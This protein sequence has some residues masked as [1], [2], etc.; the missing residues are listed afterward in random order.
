MCFRSDWDKPFIFVSVNLL[1]RTASQFC[2]RKLNCFQVNISDK[3]DPK[4]F[5]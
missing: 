4:S 5:S 2:L 3:V 1:K